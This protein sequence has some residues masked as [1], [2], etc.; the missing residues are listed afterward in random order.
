MHTICAPSFYLKFP[1]VGG[2][3]GSKLAVWRGARRPM[4]R[5]R[6]SG[7]SHTALVFSLPQYSF[8]AHILSTHEDLP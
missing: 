3:S 6:T 5:E 1:W 2:G 4:S 8:P 7:H